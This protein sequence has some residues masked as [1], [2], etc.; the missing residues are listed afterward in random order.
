MHFRNFIIPIITLA[1][2]L[3]HNLQAQ[4]INYLDFI[5]ETSHKIL[6]ELSTKKI[7]YE[8]T[9]IDSSQ[10]NILVKNKK[11]KTGIDYVISTMIYLE[12]G[13]C[14]KLKFIGSDKY[15]NT[16]FHSLGIRREKVLTFPRHFQYQHKLLAYTMQL[17]NNKFY[18]ELFKSDS[19]LTDITEE[20]KSSI[21]NIEIERLKENL[22]INI[23]LPKRNKIQQY[24]L[25][26]WVVI[27]TSVDS[28]DQRIHLEGELLSIETD[29]VYILSQQSQFGIAKNDINLLAVYTFREDPA[30]YALITGVALIPNFV[31]GL[32][33]PE[34]FAEFLLIGLPV[35]LGGII[36]ISVTAGKP[37]PVMYYPGD[38]PGIVNIRPYARFPQ[39]IP[40]D[41]NAAISETYK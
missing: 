22:K 10:F 40:P 41:F 20:H 26:A 5:D 16:A 38:F 28:S 39:G 24:A 6:T 13:I 3:N 1:F 30:K 17:K 29:S 7:N 8:S 34:Y 14:K 36:N 31:A 21:P 18:L 2:L 15:I 9:R 33:Q 32:V 4:R 12:N 35:A 19:L 25:G 11:S 27:I 23:K 37:L